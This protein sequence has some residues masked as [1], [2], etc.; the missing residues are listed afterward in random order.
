MADNVAIVRTAYE[1]LAQGDVNTFLDTLDGQV[2]W[3][4]P[5]HH[6]LWPGKVSSNA[7]SETRHSRTVLSCAPETTNAP[8]GEKATERTFAVWPIKVWSRAPSAARHSLM[9]KSALP[10]AMVLLSEE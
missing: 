8:S 9:V 4:L 10:E 1:A 6:P 7:P 3:H 2:E 5:E